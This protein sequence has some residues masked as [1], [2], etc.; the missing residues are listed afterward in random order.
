MD[1]NCNCAR[2]RKERNELFPMR[3]YVCPICG[4][5]RCPHIEWHGFKCTH[6]NAVDQVG[7]VGESE[8]LDSYGVP[9]DLYTEDEHKY[10]NSIPDAF[11]RVSLL[12]QIRLRK[13]A[14]ENFKMIEQENNRHIELIRSLRKEYRN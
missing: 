3:M 12:H 1:T 6:S 9:D 7:E 5:K 2:C 10:V 4:N 8:I 14:E 13:I 11:L